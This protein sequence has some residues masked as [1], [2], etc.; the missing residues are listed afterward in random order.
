LKE[1]APKEGAPMGAVAVDPV[2]YLLAWRDG[3]G[4]MRCS[5]APIAPS[6]LQDEIRALVTCG[7][8]AVTVWK[9]T[10]VEVTIISHAQISGLP[11]S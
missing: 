1:G 6:D 9:N 5:D 7:N 4:N 11:S 10:V 8:T 3:Q 2:E